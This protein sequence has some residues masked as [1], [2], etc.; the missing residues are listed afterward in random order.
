MNNNDS[1][2]TILYI[3]LSRQSLAVPKHEHVKA[4]I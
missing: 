4:N 3:N 1:L 2:T